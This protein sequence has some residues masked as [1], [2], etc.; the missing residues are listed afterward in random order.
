MSVVLGAG[1]RVLGA[2]GGSRVPGSGSR[3]SLSRPRRPEPS[4]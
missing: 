3:D 4:T 1:F 2:S